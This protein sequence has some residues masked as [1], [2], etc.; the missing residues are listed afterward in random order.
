MR[1]RKSSKNLLL[2]LG[3]D[4]KD[5]HVR[6]TR[7]KNFYLFGGSKPTHDVMQEKAVKFNEQ[8]KARGKTIDDVDHEEFNE[9]AGKI[10]LDPLLRP[11]TDPK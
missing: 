11:N 8:L 10:G 4:A 3:L 6:V 1:E 2:G 9:I 5:G 7:G